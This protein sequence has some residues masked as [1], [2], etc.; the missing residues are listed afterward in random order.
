MGS[1]PRFYRDKFIRN[2]IQ[3]LVEH[4]G[5]GDKCSNVLKGFENTNQ[6]LR[7]ILHDITSVSHILEARLTK[8]D[9]FDFQEIIIS[10]LYRLLHLYPLADSVPRTQV[11]RLCFFALLSFMSTM[12]FQPSLHEKLRYKLLTE[13]LRLSLMEASTFTFIDDTALFWIL[14]IGG[15]SGLRYNDMAWLKPRIKTMASSLGIC[16]WS[17]AREKLCKYPWISVFHDS[18]AQELWNQINRT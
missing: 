2:E 6:D 16:E 11:D 18:P 3:S 12:V 8:F 9:P 1:R 5:L 10:I 14:Y 13:K 17:G 4:H 15:I 7:D